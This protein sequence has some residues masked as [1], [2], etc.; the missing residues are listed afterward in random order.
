MLATGVQA[1][2]TSSIVVD[3]KTGET[4]SARDPDAPRHPASLTKMMTLYIVF[5]LIEQKRI[6]YDTKIV[7]TEHAASQ[8]P[9][10][11]ELGV[12]HSLTVRDAVLALITKSAND[13]AAAIG[14]NLAGSE[15]KFAKIM[16]WKA[17][18]IG[19]SATTFKNAS[20]LP[21]PA[22]ITTARD[23]ATLGLRL[24]HDFP[25]HYKLFGTK[26]FEYNGD[27]H[28]NHNTLLFNYDGT[29]GIKT[30]YTRA[31]GFNL[32]TS[33]RREDKHVIGVVLGGSSASQRNITMR[34]LLTAGLGKAR[35]LQRSILAHLPSFKARH[36]VALRT[37]DT[38][39][40]APPRPA[41]TTTPK[42]H[43]ADTGS[44]TPTQTRVALSAATAATVPS[45]LGMQ[46]ASAEGPYHVQV[47][48]FGSATEAEKRLADISGRAGE[49]VTGH[50]TVITNI[51]VAGNRYHRA[52]FAGFDEAAAS[53]A[54][55]TL[56]QKQ[57][58]CL[59]MRSD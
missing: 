2:S 37:Q 17:H 38:A 40:A 43:T 8:P 48:A 42:T 47:G 52:R 7:I 25:E 27:T 24:V 59:V 53:K 41:A 56:K 49:I 45:G 46:A 26:H 23:M 6:S 32:V 57:I 34:G 5:D 58:E 31:S 35:A 50:A 12:G 15:E 39:A 16:T 30:G 51:T 54:C 22:Q 33:V 13:V 11:L 19:M 1:A 36:P 21:D 55:Q 44:A 28:K 18:Q 10:N 3:A 20:G 14:D 9:S 29:D 4:L